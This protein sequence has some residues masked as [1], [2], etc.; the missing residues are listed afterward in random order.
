MLDEVHEVIGRHVDAADPDLPGAEDVA[1][2]LQA[3]PVRTL[4]L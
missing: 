4:R 1:V 2:L 3:F